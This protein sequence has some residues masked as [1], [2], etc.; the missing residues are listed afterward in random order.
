MPEHKYAAI[1]RAIADGKV[2]Q[3]FQPGPGIWV[4]QAQDL[5]LKEIAHGNYNVDSYRVKPE[6]IN[7]N[8]V[9]VPKPEADRLPYDATYYYPS[10][11]AYGELS[12][13]SRWLDGEDDRTLLSRGL[14]HLTREAAET[15]A[16]ALLS[17]TEQPCQN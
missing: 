13:A 1:L 12:R 2:V 7:I 5:T 17:F 15:H 6:P 4:D 10:L 3:W 11:S 8:G 9:E 16:K 14:V